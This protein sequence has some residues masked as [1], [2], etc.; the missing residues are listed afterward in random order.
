VKVGDIVHVEEAWSTIN[1]HW[2]DATVV[3]DGWAIVTEITRVDDSPHFGVVWLISGPAEGKEGIPY[4]DR[5]V[6]DF[7][8]V[9]SDQVPRE[10]HTRLAGL[11]LTG[12]INV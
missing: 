11:R 8:V 4:L 6:D 10:V 2:D 12:E 5:E 1:R 9:P 7:E 3:R